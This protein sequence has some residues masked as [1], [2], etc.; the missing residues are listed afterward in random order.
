MGQ[1]F[2]WKQI[3][4]VKWIIQT[5]W[6]H[7]TRK[8]AQQREREPR[9]TLLLLNTSTH[10]TWIRPLQTISKVLKRKLYPY[11][12]EPPTCLTLHNIN[13]VWNIAPCNIHLIPYIFSGLIPWTP[14][15]HRFKTE[16]QSNDACKNATLNISA[17]TL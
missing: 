1:E 9:V 3:F 6:K 5:L 12:L 13:Y 8:W 2:W 7:L 4:F 14:L 11:N 17:N 10:R 16:M 15:F